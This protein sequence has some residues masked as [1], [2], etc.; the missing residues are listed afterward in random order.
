MYRV[1]GK[2]IWGFEYHNA[3]YVEI[4]YRGNKDKL[5]KGDFKQLFLDRFPNLKLVKAESYKYSQSENRDEMYL[6]EKV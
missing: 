4:D 1:S 5:W 6:L 3:E 2:Y